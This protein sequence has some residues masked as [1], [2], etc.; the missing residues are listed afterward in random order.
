M[1]R[2]KYGWTEEKKLLTVHVNISAVEFPIAITREGRI[3]T[4]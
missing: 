2:E 1:V 3:I 4:A